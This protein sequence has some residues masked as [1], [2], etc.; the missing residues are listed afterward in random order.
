MGQERAR[1]RNDKQAGGNFGDD[2][3]VLGCTD[4]FC[5]CLH[6]SKFIKL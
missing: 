1:G 2:G 4:V 5:R 3:Y 6:M